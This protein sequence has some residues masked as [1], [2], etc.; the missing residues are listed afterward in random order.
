MERHVAETNR[1]L[2]TGWLEER[3]G[4]QAIRE[5]AEHKRVPVHSSMHWY[6]FG[7]IS[8]FLVMVQVITGILLMLYYR[9]TVAEA[10]ESVRFI[11]TRVEFGWL[12]RS[13]HSWS[14]NLLI[15]MVFVHMFSVVFTHAYRPPRELTWLTGIALLG[16]MMAFGF[17][18][19]L[20]P[21]NKISYFA[22]KVGADVAASTPLIGEAIARF[23]R[24]GEDVGGATLTRFFAFHVVVLPVAAAML[25]MIHLLLVQK[26]GMSTPPWIA[27]SKV[28]QMKFF[29]NFLLRELMVWY[30][31]MAVLG[32]LAAIFPWELG[33]KAD[34]FAPAPAGIRP[35]W[36]FLAQF[37]T[38]KLIPSHVLFMEGELLGIFGFGLLAVLWAGLP[39]W[40]IRKDGSARTRLVVSAAVFLVAYLVVFTILGYVK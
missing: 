1:A 13:I 2:K 11:M 38:L 31:T 16:L 39:A 20:L 22:T 33:E 36:Y 19:Y 5:L 29:P 35:E 12:I 24:G 9:P 27:A 7:G 30:C 40:A 6:Y 3:L 15:F 28:R 8:L 25:L 37:Y 17:S 21:W 34:P 10:F 18:G 32:A 14:A 26:S 4:L 23:L